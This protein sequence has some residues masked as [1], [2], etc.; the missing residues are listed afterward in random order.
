M[1][2]GSSVTVDPHTGWGMLVYNAGGAFNIGGS[3]GQGCGSVPWA[4]STPEAPQNTL[5]G[6]DP[7][8]AYQ[9]IFFFEARDYQGQP[10]NHYFAPVGSFQIN[11][12][13]YMNPTNPYGTPNTSSYSTLNLQQGALTVYWEIIVG[14]LTLTG[15]YLNVYVAPEPT[16]IPQVALVQ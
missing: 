16:N 3:F 13:I 1:A 2:S 9:N 6:S 10:Q 12:I 11:G 7:D 15:S 5:V 8:S 4:N 14:A